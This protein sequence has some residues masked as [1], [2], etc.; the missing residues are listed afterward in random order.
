M[1]YSLKELKM[2]RNIHAME[3]NGSIASY[4]KETERGF[5]KYETEKFF[6]WIC[7]IEKDGNLKYILNGK[8]K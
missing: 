5:F 2:L 6:N 3:M 4:E 7:E 8:T 1:K